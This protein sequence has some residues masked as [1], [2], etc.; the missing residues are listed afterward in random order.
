MRRARVGVAGLV[1]AL[2]VGC[3]PSPLLWSPDG[4]WLAYTMA[5]RPADRVLAPGWLFE[6]GAGRA[7][8]GLGPALG[9]PRGG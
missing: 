2:L 9:R 3:V 6:P 1:S 7:A 5:V 8:A 4:K